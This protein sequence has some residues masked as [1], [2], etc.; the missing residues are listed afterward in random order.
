MK[1]CMLVGFWSRSNHCMRG[2]V[3]L[4]SWCTC[5]HLHGLNKSCKNANKIRLGLVPSK[6]VKKLS[7][8]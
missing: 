4:P 8:V 1:P 2:R 3:A 6:T 7:D 5:K